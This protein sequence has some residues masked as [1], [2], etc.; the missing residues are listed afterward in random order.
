MEINNKNE[1]SLVNQ[2]E[3]QVY[4]ENKT[5]LDLSL[6][7]ETNIKIFY[8]IKNNLLNISSISAFKDFGVDVFN[9]KDSFFNDICSPYSDS[10][11]DMV[12]KDRIK[13]IFK[14][15][16][17]CDEGCIYDEFNIEYNTISC[18]CNVKTNISINETSL[19]LEKLDDIKIESNFG[20]IKCYKLVFSWDGKSKNIGF[21]IF[22]ILFLPHFPLLF[23]YFCKGIKPIKEYII[24][25][26]KKYG[27]IKVNKNSIKNNKK[28]IYKNVS[29]LLSSPPK[30]KKT[31]RKKLTASSINNI[32]HPE[33]EIIK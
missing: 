2:V 10:K 8:A 12:L 4:D 18:N 16:S 27:Y 24:N 23:S 25:E 9:I 7:N 31:N 17:L 11:N 21:W 19:N 30:F 26:M 33:N 13:Y 1:K 14:N 15:Y 3:Y 32:K 5:L 28:I 20:L 29:N 22:L 6:C